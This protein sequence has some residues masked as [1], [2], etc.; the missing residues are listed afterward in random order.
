V[1]TDD[2][3]IQGAGP[4]AGDHKTAEEIIEMLAGNMGKR[5]TDHRFYVA[6]I[7]T[8]ALQNPAGQFSARFM[9][10]YPSANMGDFRP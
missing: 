5:V 10:G 4:F 2:P 1:V 3:P 7:L 8:G 9:F 6:L